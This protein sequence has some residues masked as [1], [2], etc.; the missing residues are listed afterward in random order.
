MAKGE[1][2]KLI[3]TTKYPHYIPIMEKCKVRETRKKLDL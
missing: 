2:N 1:G 3:V